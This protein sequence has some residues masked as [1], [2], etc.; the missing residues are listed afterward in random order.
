MWLS[1]QAI[2]ADK[3]TPFNMD[4]VRQVDSNGTGQAKLWYAND[5]FIITVESK[6]TV[7]DMLD[8]AIRGYNGIVSEEIAF[9]VVR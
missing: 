7:E 8:A 5:E 2:D 6:E 9:A 3:K 4:H 1:L